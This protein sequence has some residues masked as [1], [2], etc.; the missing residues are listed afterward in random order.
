MPGPWELL[1]VLAIVMLLFGTSK[2]TG[3]GKSLGGAI[4]DFRDSMK[5]EPPEGESTEDPPKETGNTND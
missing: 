5:S 2:I 4:R 3:I 1:I